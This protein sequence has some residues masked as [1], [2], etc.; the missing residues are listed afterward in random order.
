M[1]DDLLTSDEPSN[2]TIYG[3]S[4]RYRGI[5]GARDVVLVNA[6]TSMRKVSATV[7]T[8]TSWRHWPGDDLE[9]RVCGFRVA[10]YDTPR[11]TAAAWDP[12]TNPSSPWAS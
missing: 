12:E 7:T 4:D 10:E 2:T 11:G 9:R 8:S 1:S 6:A 5:E 3:L